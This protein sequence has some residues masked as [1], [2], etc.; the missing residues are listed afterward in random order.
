MGANPTPAA[1]IAALEADLKAAQA[2]VAAYREFVRDA[3][4]QGNVKTEVMLTR[5][6]AVLVSDPENAEWWS[7]LREQALQRPNSMLAQWRATRASTVPS[8]E[9][10]HPSDD[11]AY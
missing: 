8:Q 5:G 4:A 11:T 9:T 10:G 1:R 2:Q 7:E 6:I 3:V